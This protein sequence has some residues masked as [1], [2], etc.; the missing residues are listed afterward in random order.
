VQFGLI[1]VEGLKP[2]HNARHGH[3]HHVASLSGLYGY[4]RDEAIG[5]NLSVTGFVGPLSLYAQRCQMI[6]RKSIGLAL[7]ST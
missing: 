5:F 1:R 3:C 6:D 7:S 4:L 2:E